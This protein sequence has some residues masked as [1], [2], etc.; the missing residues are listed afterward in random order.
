MLYAAV[1]L[2]E[3][4]TWRWSTVCGG[5]LLVTA[6]GKANLVV[7]F[8]LPVLI[9]GLRVLLNRATPRAGRIALIAWPVVT[10]VLFLAWLRHADAMNE[11]SN[12]MTFADL[13][14]WYLGT[15]FTD[16]EVWRTVL[17]RMLEQLTPLGAIVVV[18]GALT[19]PGLR[20]PF[21][22]ETGALIVGSAVSIGVFANLNRVHDY[23]QLPYYSVLSLLGGIGLCAVI[24]G[25]SRVSRDGALR[26]TA[27][28]AITLALLWWVALMSSYFAKD[29]V[30]TGWRSQGR[31]LSANTP[32]RRLLLIQENAD[33]NEPNIW[34]E[35]RR[36]GWRVRND[37]ERTA[38]RIVRS[39]PDLGAIVVILGAGGVPLWAR[40]LADERGFRNTH[41]SEFIVVFRAPG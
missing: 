15:T 8:G 26:V 19:I 4:F 35:A 18:L 22:L 2:A 30:N 28:F 34:Y 1:R 20:T 9:I 32:D 33:P 31:E 40:T 12:G 25:V 27:T 17:G 14:H 11:A 6:L 10:G 5:A 7:I 29:A 16:T 39:T 3:G 36:I 24:D 23:Y 41:T 13:R 38:T 21:R 37:D